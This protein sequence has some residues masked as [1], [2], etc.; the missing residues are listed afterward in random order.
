LFKDLH[1]H[2]ENVTLTKEYKAYRNTLN[3]LLKLA[4]Q[5]YYH[6]LLDEHK[7]NSKKYEKS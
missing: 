2:Y 4:K 3:R 5:N 7:D 6:N 1:K